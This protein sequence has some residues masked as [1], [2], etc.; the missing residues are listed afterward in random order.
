MHKDNEDNRIYDPASQLEAQWRMCYPCT[1]N[2]PHQLPCFGDITRYTTSPYCKR[3]GACNAGLRSVG[4]DGMSG[5]PG[6][7][8][9]A[10]QAAAAA[11]QPGFDVDAELDRLGMEEKS[12]RESARRKVGAACVFC[13][14]DGCCGSCHT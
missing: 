1:P 4:L 7:A 5:L 2:E 8:A 10:Q 6:Q 14:C 11:A 9:A 13:C 3:C 12:L